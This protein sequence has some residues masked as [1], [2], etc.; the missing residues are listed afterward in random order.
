MWDIVGTERGGRKKPVDPACALCHLEQVEPPSEPAERARL[1]PLAWAIVTGVGVGHAPVLRS[2]LAALTGL[3][4]AT[5]ADRLGAR[6]Y[7][8]VTVGITGV[9]VCAADAECRRVGTAPTAR[10]LV[11]GHVAGFLLAMAP[12]AR[13]GWNLFV[14]FALFRIVDLWQPEPA[15]TL[16]RG[17]GGGV[18]LI[19]AP[20][21]VGGYTA[22]ALY[23]ID[24]T[25]GVGAFWNYLIGGL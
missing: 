10:R 7:L 1:W 17:P 2:T 15:R 11:G 23:A 20:L 25:G 21:V 14:G 3:G 16:R 5:L 19:G 22:L 18:D 9:A 13:T 24:R 12:V 6:A 4:A 8:L